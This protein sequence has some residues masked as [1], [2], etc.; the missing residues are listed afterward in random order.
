MVE[1]TAYSR[2][3]ALSSLEILPK[4]T[5]FRNFYEKHNWDGLAGPIVTAELRCRGR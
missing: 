3:V 2:R 4:N 5:H 1:N